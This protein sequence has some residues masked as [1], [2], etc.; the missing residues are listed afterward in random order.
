MLEGIAIGA[1]IM[2]FYDPD[3]GRSR[4]CTLK[5]QTNAQV[6]RKRQALDVMTRDLQNRAQGVQHMAK[7]RLN[8][9]PVHDEVLVQRIRAELGR[10]V[11]HTSSIVVTADNGH[12]T[13][14]GPV[15]AN[16]VQDLVRVVRWTPGVKSVDN[17]LDQHESGEGVPG[18][19]GHGH[20]PHKT[21][22]W[23]PATSL[24]ALG[25]GAL[26]TLYGTT[27]RGITGMLTTFLGSGMVAKAFWD[28]EHRFDPIN[29][30][31]TSVDQTQGSR[32]E[33]YE[34]EPSTP[35]MQSAEVL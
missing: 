32:R 18:L 6:R 31:H 35:V 5:D 11:T 34:E 9:E 29:G 10:H 25:A 26:L 3:R 27:R 2:Y 19:Q 7:A 17:N 23:S 28:T 8:N 14:S 22:R 21:A 13:L 33:S 24:L 12:V 20:L 1:A 30:G 16:E 4:R 15:L